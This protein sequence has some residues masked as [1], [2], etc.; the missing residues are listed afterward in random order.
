MCVSAAALTAVPLSAAEAKVAVFACVPEWASLA[1]AI[2]GDAVEVTLASSALENPEGIKPTPALIADLQK[3]DL[4]VCTGAGLE[5]GWLDQMLDRAANPKVTAGAPGHFLASSFVKLQEDHH[6]GAK[7]KGHLHGEGNP[8]IQGDPRNVQKVAAQLAKR[9]SAIDA[10]NKA[11]YAENAKT[12]IRDLDKLTKDLAKKAAP[13]KGVH[14]AVQHE[15]SLYLLE[16]LGI[17]AAATV[18]P[19][20]GIPPGP[21]HL[22]K[23]I[24][25]VAKQKMKFVVHA[26]YED[27]SPSKFVGEKSGI[28]LVKL[29][30]TVGGTP[31]AKDFFGFYE[32]S[33][34]RLLD[35]LSGRE[36]S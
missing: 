32:D 3:A 14:I 20:P 36:R 25:S 2:G 13:L 15:H 9:L 35:G 31:E 27:P 1:K 23:I 18:E 6:G 12:F 28:P 11:V 4:I 22:T 30:F 33:V 17:E 29:P 19:E 8:H 16:W 34:T 5:E 7:E 26:A 21:Q 24:D 10:A